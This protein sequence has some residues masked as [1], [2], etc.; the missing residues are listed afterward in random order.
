MGRARLKSLLGFAVAVVLLGVILWFVGYDEV[1]SALSNADAGIVALTVP[2]ATLWLTAWGL[3]LYLVLR[4]V[5]APIAPHRAVFVF[6]AAVFVNNAT[7]FGQAGGEPISA[8][9]IST[10]SDSR[11]ETG[12]A[13]IA[14]VDTLHFIPSISLAVVGL[15]F[16]GLSA[17]QLS[18]NLIVASVAVAVLAAIVPLAG[19]FGWKH[20]M[21]IERFI[22]EK[23]TPPI[24]TLSRYLPFVG[25]PTAADIEERIEGFFD[26]VGKVAGDRRTLIAAMSLSAIGW[27][28]LSTSLW[29]SLAALGH[30]VAFPAI[31][32][33]VPLGSI[34]GTTPLPGG[35]GG[36]E[37]AF[38]ALLLPLGIPASVAFSAVLIHRGATYWLP[39]LVGGGAAAVLSLEARRARG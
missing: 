28:C 14:S 21:G 25:A 39:T 20:R 13:A 10:A 38:V 9:F 27:L 2:V 1:V 26:A 24:Q 30:V 11:Y 7:P 31:L 22:I 4:A 32:F 16:V 23:L 35:L 37:A 3:S 8:M 17:V 29:L 34:A 5:G 6:T 33:V 18:R 36:L 12:L 19:Y 15:G